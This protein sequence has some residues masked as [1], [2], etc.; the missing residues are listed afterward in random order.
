MTNPLVVDGTGALSSMNNFMPGVVGMQQTAGAPFTPPYAYSPETANA[1][2]Q[3]NIQATAGPRW[4][5]TMSMGTRFR[6]TLIVAAALTVSA[7]SG[8]TWKVYEKSPDYRV[9]RELHVVI[10]ARSGQG[11]QEAALQAAKQL[12][13]TVEE[14]LRKKYIK[15]TVV[16]GALDPPPPPRAE[17]RILNWDA[18]TRLARDLIGFGAGGATLIVEC[19]VYLP[20]SSAPL[21]HGVVRGRVSS[22]YEDSESAVDD[23]AHAIAKEIAATE[24]AEE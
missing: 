18:D 16:I 17:L 15:A 3:T 4:V 21:F 19:T 22:E 14:A 8:T 10:Y 12:A 23:T 1:A 6:H 13:V 24:R 2:L 5:T 11:S 9:P 7:C 20:K